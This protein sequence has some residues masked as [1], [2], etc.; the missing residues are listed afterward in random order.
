MARD[1]LYVSA[2]ISGINRYYLRRVIINI[3][4]GAITNGDY[5]AMDGQN[6]DLKMVFFVLKHLPGIDRLRE[7]YR[8]VIELWES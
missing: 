4:A 2:A 5:S 7:E 8:A 1:D 6:H 3:L